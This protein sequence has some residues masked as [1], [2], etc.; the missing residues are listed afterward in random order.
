MY[1]CVCVI[2]RVWKHERIGCVIVGVCMD[3]HVCRCKYYRPAHV[4][5]HVCVCV[6]V[7]VC[8]YACDCLETRYMPGECVFVLTRVPTLNTRLHIRTHAHAYTH[9]LTQ[10]YVHTRIR[11][12]TQ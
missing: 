4:P 7:C 2:V 5:A 8:A 11:A 9:T 3:V 10:A 1:V 6:C 12:H